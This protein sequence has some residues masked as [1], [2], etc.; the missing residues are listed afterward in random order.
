MLSERLKEET[1]TA[2]VAVE[3]LIIP[4]IKKLDSGKSYSRLLHLFYGYFKPLEQKIEVFVG[5]TVLPDIKERRKADSILYDVAF[6]AEQPQ[7]DLVCKDLPTISNAAE[8]LGAM[9]VMEGSTLGG[10]HLTKMIAEK[11]HFE[12]GQGVGFF[13]GYGSETFAKWNVFKKHL[14][15]FGGNRQTEDKVVEAANETFE[16]FRS[17]I[18]KN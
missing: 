9:Y 4:R 3:K 5:D 10:V 1:H 18:E 13:S 8:A 12:D 14:N 2:H 17:W 15:E 11:M 6:V 16:K 7:E